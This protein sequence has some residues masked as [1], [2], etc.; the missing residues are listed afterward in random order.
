MGW[1]EDWYCRFNPYSCLF[2]EKENYRLRHYENKIIKKLR[3]KSLKKVYIRP[4]RASWDYYAIITPEKEI[5][6]YFSWKKIL[7]IQKTSYRKEKR[8]YFARSRIY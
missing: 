3:K 6:I 8:I 2:K 7:I 1:S 4:P 5:N